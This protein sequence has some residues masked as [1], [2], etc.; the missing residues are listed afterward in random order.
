[1][2]R[3]LGVIVACL[4]A[5]DVAAGAESSFS[6]P[7]RMHLAWYSTFAVA[8]GDIDG[9]GRKDVVASAR[10]GPEWATRLLMFRQTPDGAMASPIQVEVGEQSYGEFRMALADFDGD[11]AEDI[12]MGRGDTHG[13]QVIRLGDDGTPSVTTFGGPGAECTY[14]ATGDVDLDGHQDVVCQDWHSTASVYFGDGQGGFHSWYG[15]R[16]V[17]GG[18]GAD[19]NANTIQ[20][21]D[22]TGDGFPDFL[23]N[24]S[25]SISF[26]V[27]VNNGMGGFYSAVAY[28]E[29]GTQSFA[30]HVAD[31]DGDGANEVL[32][33]TPDNR[34]G[35]M[36]NV[37]RRGSNGYLAL[38]ER[39]AV[40]HSPTAVVAG[41]FGNNAGG[42][43]AVAH[44]TFNALTV[45]GEG[46]AGLDSQFV[47]DLPG[48]G[49][50]IE[51]WGWRRQHALAIGDLDSDGCID[52]VA[53]ANSGLIVLYGCEPFVPSMPVSDFDGDGVS[54]LLWFKQVTSELEMWHWGESGH[55]CARPC[56]W[57]LGRIMEAQAVGDFDGDGS[58]D[59]VFRDPVSG[60]NLL[61]IGAFYDRM[62]T[63]VTN[64]G[65]R[66]VGAGDFDGDDQADLLW[67]NAVTGVN[68][69][70]RS[71]DYSKQLPMYAVSDVRWEVAAVG[72][73]DGD[74]RADILWRHTLT[75]W[76]AI[77]RSGRY[78]VQVPV[79]AVTNLDWKVRGAGDF[80]GDGRDDIVW[81]NMRSG[82]NAIWLSGDFSSQRPVV[83]VTNIH[84]DVAAI[85]DYNGD[86][87]SDLL[88]R[89][90]ESGAN[91]IWYSGQFATQR[92]LRSMIQSYR[93]VR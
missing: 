66:I 27:Y 89:N 42:D 62:L 93:P 70:W 53:A 22:V 17:Y 31:L 74:L 6:R 20:L 73:F 64:P 57:S 85:A 59:V 29:L 86:G 40:H 8:V 21:A 39:S 55:R 16:T 44:Y 11:G 33:T 51:I 45:L 49:S 25:G 56:P 4:M 26:Y 12:V 79:T 37:Y 83:A 34:P 1:M 78:D 15:F 80:D 48:F 32:T 9:D 35:A 2:G 63:T 81:R 23:A 91:V 88:W 76:N 41:R 54:D 24:P 14:V 7:Y 90:S 60:E 68:A 69:I 28:P 82:A 19:F 43:I 65:W 18:Y 5:F 77:W 30:L 72:D 47:H 67:R 3:V 46:G 87:R 61:R 13:I 50:H 84:W 71:A 10:Y 92:V 38:S 52:L 75:G 36:L 58:S